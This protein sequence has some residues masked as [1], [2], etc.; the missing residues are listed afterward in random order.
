MRQNEEACPT[1]SPNLFTQSLAASLGGAA[2]RAATMWT[3]AEGAAHV[4]T[5]ALGALGFAVLSYFV[6]SSF[7]IGFTLLE[8]AGILERLAPEVK[9]R[10]DRYGTVPVV[11]ERA[12][13]CCGS[14]TVSTTPG[15]RDPC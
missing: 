6:E 7:F 1:H 15:L 8:R 11:P 9:G 2:C 13:G 10:L 14:K 4:G 12:F 5:A 3:A